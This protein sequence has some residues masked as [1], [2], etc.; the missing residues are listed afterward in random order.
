MS[1]SL[2]ILVIGSFGLGEAASAYRDAFFRLGHL[3]G[4]VDVRSSYR[5]SGLNSFVNRVLRPIAP[6]PDYW[7]TQTCN[8]LIIGKAKELSPHLIF[9]CDPIHVQPGTL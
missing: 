4:E 3:V 5:V 9:F 2:R 7:G 1:S 6:T 8:E